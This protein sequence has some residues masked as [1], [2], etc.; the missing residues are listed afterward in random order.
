MTVIAARDAAVWVCRETREVLVLPPWE[1][2]PKDRHW[3]DPAGAAYTQWRG[4]TNAQRVQLMLETAIDLAAQGFE[5]ATV[6]KAFAEVREFRALVTTPF[7]ERNR[8][9]SNA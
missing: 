9:A 5:M 3:C 2:P 7:E 4:M 6:L 8:E 1:D